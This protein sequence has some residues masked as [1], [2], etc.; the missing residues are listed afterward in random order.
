MKIILFI[1]LSFSFSAW[2]N[3]EPEGTGGGSPSE[4]GQVSSMVLSMS[5]SEKAQK[6][7]G[8]I[9]VGVGAG[10]MNTN[11]NPAGNV[12]MCLYGVAHI[13][14][15]VQLFQDAQDTD[16]KKRAD[17]GGGGSSSASNPTTGG[18]GGDDDGDG[19]L[20][21]TGEDADDPRCNDDGGS[22]DLGTVARARLTLA[23]KKNN[24]KC[25]DLPRVTMPNGEVVNLDK[26]EHPS[27]PEEEMNKLYQS[28]LSSAKS[29][30]PSLFSSSNKATSLDDGET[31]SEE[32]LSS[33]G[34][35]GASSYYG[36]SGGKSGPIKIRRSL[37]S[38]DNNEEETDNWYAQLLQ[39]QIKS[40]K[41]KN[42]SGLKFKPKKLGNDQIGTS[43]DDIFSMMSQG[44][45]GY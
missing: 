30:H 26:I 24:L 11:C 32:T 9:N 41:K 2:A 35:L 18:G 8:V 29:S 4:W 28:A 34:S 12:A 42:Q 21:C 36:S 45:Q 44:Y 43:H 27:I 33:E 16:R 14:S 1:V 25:N 31:S 3:T 39:Q 15:A 23:C 37:N 38:T 17:Y 13:A 19:D 6:V 22:N 10:L 5:D 20:R 7:G 40:N